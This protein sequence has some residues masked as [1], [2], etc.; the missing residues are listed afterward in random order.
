MTEL[1]LFSLATAPLEQC[2][3]DQS[4]G[5][6][7]GF[8]WKSGS[9]HYLVSNWHVF[10]MR[11]FFSGE[12]LAPKAPVPNNFHTHF[13]IHRGSF[14]KQQCKIWIRDE[15]DTPQWYIHPSRRVDIAVIPLNL[16]TSIATLYPI[17]VIANAKLRIEVGMDV[18]LLGYPFKIAP[19]FYP[20]WKRGSIASEPQLAPLTTNFMYVD[21]ASRPGMSGA[22][23][24]RRSWSSHVIEAGYVDLSSGGPINRFVGVYSGRI[25]THLSHEMQLGLVWSAFLIDEIIAAQCIDQ[26]ADNHELMP[27]SG[28][29][30]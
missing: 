22:P 20:I 17:N 3:N 7:T 4:L 11:D 1:D 8:I 2:F 30:I 25:P 29:Q 26:W 19:P 10:A 9:N 14:E 24:I 12:K 21:T 6:G 15:N 28:T 5:H 18:F 23:V 27:A 16:N 13:N